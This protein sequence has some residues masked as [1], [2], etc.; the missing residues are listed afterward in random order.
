[1]HTNT[2]TK[3]SYIGQTKYKWKHISGITEYL[4][5]I[6]IRNKYKEMKLLISHLG[7]VSK[8]KEKSHKGWYIES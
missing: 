3:K 4:S 1:M 7:K 5:P 2:I 8:G 6:D